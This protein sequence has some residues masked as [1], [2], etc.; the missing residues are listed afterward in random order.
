MAPGWPGP[1][2]DLPAPGTQ[3]LPEAFPRVGL[4]RATDAWDLVGA[5]VGVSG[6]THACNPQPRMACADESLGLPLAE[7]SLPAEGPGPIPQSIQKCL[8]PLPGGCS[9]WQL[10]L[11]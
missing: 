1:D 10:H 4:C 8:G 9:L 7:P 11:L 5:W 6:G 2:C 3:T